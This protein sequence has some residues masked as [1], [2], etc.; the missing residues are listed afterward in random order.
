MTLSQSNSARRSSFGRLELVNLSKSFTDSCFPAI[1]NINLTCEAGEFVVVV[2]PSG[3]GKST[4]LNIAAGLL[5]PSSGEVRLDGVRIT[6]PGPSRTIVFQEHGLFPWLTAYQNVE[7]GL[8][9]KGISKSERQDRVQAALKMVHLTSAGEKLIHQ[10]SG[11][12]R[13]RISIA[14]A[15]VMDPPVLLMDEP[16]SAL[17]AHTRTLLHAELQD[18]WCRTKKTVLFI[19][20]SVGEAVRLADRVIIL[21]SQPGRIR[22]EVRVPIAHPRDFDSPD[23]SEVVGVIRREIEEEVNRVNAQMAQDA[24]AA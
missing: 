22:R 12:M 19:T 6:A 4:L 23:I 24:S 13:Q 11:G 14:R 1:D 15:L 16:F 21:A 2:G 18:I 17:D 9:L 7:L 8:K 5:A 3:C 20:H 10:L